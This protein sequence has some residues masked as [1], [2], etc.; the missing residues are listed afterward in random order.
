M[1]RLIV[2]V[3]V[4]SLGLAVVPTTLAQGD[5]VYIKFSNA[6]WGLYPGEVCEFGVTFEAR[7]PAGYTVV[8]TRT[9]TYLDNPGATETLSETFVSEGWYANTVYD[10]Y[11]WEQWIDFTYEEVYE[12]YDGDTRLS[13]T[14]LYAECYTQL[15][16]VDFEYVDRA[17]AVYEPPAASRTQ[18][19]LVEDTAFYAE[20]NPATILEDF[21]LEAG[22]TWFVV[23]VVEGTDGNMWFEVFTG[24]PNNAYVPAAAFG[25]TGNEIGGTQGDRYEIGGTQGDRYEIGGTQGDRYDD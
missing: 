11:F 4:L 24:G 9:I 1:K 2:L 25:M 8:H 10:E 13:Y 21:Q 18:L 17:N 3:F 22:Q 15:L 5:N 14:R 16:D 6:T 23:A 20:P 7:V 19:T 12:V